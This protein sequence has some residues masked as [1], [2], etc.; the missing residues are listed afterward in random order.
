V[1]LCDAGFGAIP[2]H[3][4]STFGLAHDSLLI[5]R[6]IIFPDNRDNLSPDESSGLLSTIARTVFGTG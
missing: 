6:R 4:T 5:I 3:R 1:R 2:T